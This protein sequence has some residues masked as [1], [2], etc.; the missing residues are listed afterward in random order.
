MS[1]WYKE[2][3]YP[4]RV[5]AFGR[6]E[7]TEFDE[8]INRCDRSYSE[9][10]KW[11]WKMI[12]SWMHWKAAYILP[13]IELKEY[14][15]SS[16]FKGTDMDTVLE[17]CAGGGRLGRILG[18]KMTDSY[19]QRDNLGVYLYYTTHGQ[20]IINYPSDV[21]KKSANDAVRE[22][23]PKTIIGSY[24]TWGSTDYETTQRKGASYYG[25]DM[26][27]LYKSVDRMILIGNEDILPHVTNPILSHPHATISDVPGLITRNDPAKNRIWIWSK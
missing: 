21:I 15:L 9:I 23:K 26:E 16:V 14:L 2:Q 20:P 1:D 4:I 17:I 10:G 8:W 22:F 27:D 5:D 13:T 19:L 25:P 6:E 18:I 12:R 3:Y 24:V 7:V 11:G